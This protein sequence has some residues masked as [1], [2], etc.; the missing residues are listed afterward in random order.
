M[1][2]ATI[3][4]LLLAWVLLACDEKEEVSGPSVPS[5]IMEQYLLFREQRVQDAMRIAEDMARSITSL[6]LLT[7]EKALCVMR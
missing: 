1:R 2:Y 3:G 6:R 4:I 5:L 7:L